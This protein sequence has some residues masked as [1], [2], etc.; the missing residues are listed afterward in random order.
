MIMDTVGTNLRVFEVIPMDFGGFAWSPDGSQ[1][2]YTSGERLETGLLS[3]NT[4][5]YKVNRDG[6]RLRRLTNTPDHDASFSW[7]SDGAWIAFTRAPCNE[8]GNPGFEQIYLIHVEGFGLIQLTNEPS[9]VFEGLSWSPWPPLQTDKTFTITE[10]GADLKLRALS[11]LS[12]SI[13][14]KLAEGE[15][16]LVLEGPVEVDEYLWWH[17]R[18]ESSGVEGWVADNPGW[19]SEE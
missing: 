5:L 16:I 4:D 12:A 14:D 8:A 13:L 1:I 6:S 15:K 19:F 2:V 7:S 3:C 11:S 10:L 9:L 17:V 18:V